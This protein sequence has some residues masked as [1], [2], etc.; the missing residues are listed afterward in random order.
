MPTNLEQYMDAIQHESRKLVHRLITSTISNGF[1]D[2]HRDLELYAL[3]I[4]TTICFGKQFE[5]VGDPE[6]V[7]LTDAIEASMKLAGV[8]ND[9]SN[10]LPILQVVDYLSGTRQKMKKFLAEKR[11]PLISSYIKEAQISS[12]PNMAKLLNEK[13]FNITMEEKVVLMCMLWC[14]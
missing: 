1:T 8:E 12:Q 2:P 3:N 11:D 7:V 5:S 9:L 4:I 6:F 10:F 13:E 14:Y